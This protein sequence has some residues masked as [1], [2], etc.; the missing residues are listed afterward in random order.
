MCCP[1]PFYDKYV[2]LSPKVNVT[3]NYYLSEYMLTV[4]AFRGFYIFRSYFNYS[5]YTDPYSK[6]LC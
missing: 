4:M 5:E 1:I 2:P 3:V 6:K